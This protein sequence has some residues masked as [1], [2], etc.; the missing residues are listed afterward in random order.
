MERLAALQKVFGGKTEG[1]A[2]FEAVATPA[3]PLQSAYDRWGLR[4]VMPEAAWSGCVAGKEV[5][6][7]CT[8][9][10]RQ[11]L[12]GRWYGPFTEALLRSPAAW[13]ARNGLFVHSEPTHCFT[14]RAAVA[15]VWHDDALALW[16]FDVAT[17]SRYLAPA[18]PEQPL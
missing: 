4:N 9:A 16:F 13:R 12:A 10:Q 17:V 11:Q 1:V 14:A 15:G 3:M 18:W 5:P 8:L 2:L 6:L 7:N